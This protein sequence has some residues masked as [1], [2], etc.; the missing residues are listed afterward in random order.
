MSPGPPGACPPPSGSSDAPSNPPGLS[1]IDYRAGR[2]A[3]FRQALLRSIPGEQAI[4]DWR[5]AAG[6]LGLQ[7]LEWWAYLADVL[8]FYNERIANESYLRTATRPESV[9]DLVALLGYEP[10]PGMAATGL[11]AAIRKAGHP[12]EPLALPAQM[13][14]SSVATPGIAAQ[15][16]EV[17]QAAAFS[18]PSSVPVTLPP[19]PA[20]PLG[21]QG[22]PASVLLAGRVNGVKA[23]DELLLVDRSFSGSDD[24]WSL[25]TVG[26]VTTQPDPATGAPT[27]LIEFSAGTWGPSLL[28]VPPWW[29][30]WV[31]VFEAGPGPSPQAASYRLLRPTA[32]AALWNRNPAGS[33]EPTPPG[34][35]PVGDQ[36][37]VEWTPPTLTIHLSAAVRTM[38]PGDLVL[39]SNS[40]GAA[41]GLGTVAG[42]SEVMW[43]VGSPLAATA[44]SSVV[45]AHTALSLNVALADLVVLWLGG[46]DPTTVGVRSGF[47]DVGTVIGRPTPTLTALPATVQVPADYRPD[48][49]TVVILQDGTGAG[50]LVEVTG[51]GPGQ[52]TLTGTGDPPLPLTAPLAVPL[53]VLPDVVAVSR[54][55]T[56]VGEVLGS[57]NAVVINQSFTLA[58]SPLTY[59]SSGAGWTSTLS[60]HVDGIQWQ[61]VPSFY[62]QGPDARV[63]V[64]T[65]SADQSVTTLTFGDGANGARLPTGSG[66]VMANYRYGSG[67]ASPPAGRLTTIAQP[68]PNLAAMLNPVAVSGGTDPQSPDD[69]RVDAPASVATFGRAISASD[70]ELVAARAPGVTRAAASWVFDPGRQRTLV[71]LWVGDDEAAVSA[72]R[73]ALIGAEDPNRPIVVIPAIGIELALSCQLVVAAAQEVAPVVAQAIS[74]VGNAAGLF[75]PTRMGIGQRLYRSAITAALSVPGVVAVHD[76]QITGTPTPFGEFADPGSGTFFDLPPT[77]VQVAGVNAGA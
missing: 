28:A 42:T 40:T 71:S 30:P 61:E 34:T 29:Q 7:V 20:L 24:H 3:D 17:A 21:A 33:G 12:A 27:T 59:L 1:Q 36:L 26:A 70:Y 47:R 50:A 69:V 49:G 54:G 67:A 2:F 68:Q 35:V 5:P 58:K 66:N 4:G 32:T 38:Q 44:V 77:S 76:L 16:F 25:V 74:A 10:A 73:A 65:R 46:A 8:T 43:S 13:R 52:L 63:F 6:D 18:G 19:D 23:G 31:E 64:V 45:I 55:T 22:S 11:L 39:L 62:G 60:V 15:T 53:Q 37:V 57:G 48:A 9:A 72:A 75:S 41:L 56:V 51:S 14:L